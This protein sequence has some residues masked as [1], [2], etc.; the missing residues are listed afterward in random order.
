M[1]VLNTNKAGLNTIG[2]NMM[3]VVTIR[4]GAS[5]PSDVPTGYDLFMAADGDFSA[6]D[7]EFYV[8]S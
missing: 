7:G 2:L 8:K 1:N 5:E 6:A 3:G 4:K